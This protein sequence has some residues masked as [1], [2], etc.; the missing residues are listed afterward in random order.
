MPALVSRTGVKQD[1]KEAVEMRG[2]A[3]GVWYAGDERRTA[4]RNLR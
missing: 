2:L 3:D 1:A 4:W